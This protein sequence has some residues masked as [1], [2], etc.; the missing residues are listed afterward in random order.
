MKVKTERRQTATVAVPCDVW[1]V[2]DIRSTAIRMTVAQGGEAPSGLKILDTLQQPVSLGKETFTK[3]NI[4]KTGTEDCVRVLKGYRRII[5]EYGTVAPDHIRV[6][7]T[8]AV[9]EA[10]NKEAFID[11]LYIATGLNV[12]VIDDS[13]VARLTYLSVKSFIET[14]DF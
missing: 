1:A 4:G 5:D 2:I 14:Y 10:L 7:A 6:I 12:E 8:T 13:D 11:R 9:R 3:K